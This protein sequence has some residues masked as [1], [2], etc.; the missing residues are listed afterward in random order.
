MTVRAKCWIKHE[1]R[2]VAPGEVFETN[3]P[4]GLTGLV[5]SAELEAPAPEWVGPSAEMM[6]TVEEKPKAPAK[7]TTRKKKSE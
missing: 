1:G 5:E 6:P 2:W 7:K 4:D 3:N